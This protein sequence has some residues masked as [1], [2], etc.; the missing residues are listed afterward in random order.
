[1]A[2]FRASAAESLLVVGEVMAFGL[3]L[4]VFAVVWFL[5]AI[6]RVVVSLPVA[7]GLVRR[8]SERRPLAPSLP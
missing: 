7:L 6:L 2:A 3:L 8:G 5:L 1:M 4:G